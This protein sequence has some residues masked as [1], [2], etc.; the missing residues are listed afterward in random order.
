MK[1]LA[2][3]SFACELYSNTSSHMADRSRSPQDN[4][5]L[6]EDEISPEHL[7][8]QVQKAQEQLLSL[9]RQQ[10]VIERQKRELEELSRR[11]EQ[12]QTGRA[13]MV[14][15]LTR[16]LVIVEREE[17]ETQRRAQMLSGIRESFTLHL[18]YFESLDLKGVE[19]QDLSKELTRAL[20]ALDDAKAEYARTIPRIGSPE[21]DGTEIANELGHSSYAHD[22]SGHDFNYWLK[23]G[24]AF[25][26]PLVVVGIL[27]LI[28]LLTSGTGR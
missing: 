10:D 2:S 1:D 25:T 28:V 23:S 13:D 5:E 18:Q 3:K 24:L 16:A 27:L 20:S 6:S 19:G 4:F 22:A 11:Q 14:D 12:L 17:F 8:S 21:S 7:D 15:K 26:L 9:K